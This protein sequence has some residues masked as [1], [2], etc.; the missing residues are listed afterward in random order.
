M[1]K[2]GALK[3]NRAKTSPGVI[4]QPKLPYKFPKRLCAA[5]VVYLSVRGTDTTHNEACLFRS[6]HEQEEA[7]LP[8]S[9]D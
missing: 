4:E 6:I 5:R 9:L 2:L 1:K 7:R 8:G 3:A